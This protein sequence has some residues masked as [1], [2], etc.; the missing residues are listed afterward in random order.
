MKAC[1]LQPALITAVTIL[2]SNGLSAEERTLTK[3]VK[4]DV[5]NVLSIGGSGLAQFG[6][7]AADLPEGTIATPKK[8]KGIDWRTTYYPQ[9]INETIELCYYL[10]FTGA[11][12]GCRKITPN[13]QGTLSDFNGERFGHG[14]RII[15]RHSVEAGGARLGYPATTDSVSIRYSY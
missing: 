1:I 10:P 6:V 8:L 13:S 4:P 7:T 3:T 11:A 9:N 5:I 14:S 2:C 15:I 12:L